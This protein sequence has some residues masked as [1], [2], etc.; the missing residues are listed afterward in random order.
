MLRT[1]CFQLHN[2]G[3][4]LNDTLYRLHVT[5]GLDATHYTLH[6]KSYMLR[7][8]CY[9]LRTTRYMLQ[10]GFVTQTASILTAAITYC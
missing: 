5:G 6:I 2:T 3:Y 8:T 7:V 10:P 9:V 1:T 4:T